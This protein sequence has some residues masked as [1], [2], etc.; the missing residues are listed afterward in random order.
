MAFPW[1]TNLYKPLNMT[2]ILGYPTNMLIESHKWLPKFTANNVITPADHLHVIG[3]ALENDGVEHEDVAMKLLATSLDEDV[4]KWFK[5]LPDNHLQS[6]EA[7]TNFL[8][9]RWTNKKDNG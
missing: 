6:Y 1:A 2:I 9:N 7:F 4:K 5:I 8:K 3:V